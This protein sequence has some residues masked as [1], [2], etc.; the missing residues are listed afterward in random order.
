MS[1][2]HHTEGGLVRKEV[3]SEG[4]GRLNLSLSSASLQQ[5]PSDLTIITDG[6]TDVHIIRN[7]TRDKFS[8]VFFVTKRVCLGS[9]LILCM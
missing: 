3:K 4:R 7:I 9:R 5:A 6:G 8:T 1:M 2:R